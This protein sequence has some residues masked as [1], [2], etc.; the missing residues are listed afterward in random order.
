MEDH[1]LILGEL[2]DE[3]TGE[4]LPDTLD[5]RYRQKLARILISRGFDRA[6]IHCRCELRVRAGNNCAI[7][8]VDIAVTV[9]QKICMI[10]R[11]GP[12]SLLTRHRPSLASSR[13]LAPYQIPVVVVSNGEDADI[14][15]GHTGEVMGRGLDHIPALPDIVSRFHEYTFEVITEN[16]AEMES[17]IVYAYEVD[18]A[19][20]C[21][22][23]VCR[24]TS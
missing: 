23:T 12:G 20:P 9:N 24:L 15:D 5:E 16:R 2:H 14:L 11:F 19:C 1:H 18:D 17:R 4:T 7:V 21:D 3:I 13:L 8:K 6:D 10:V 22:D